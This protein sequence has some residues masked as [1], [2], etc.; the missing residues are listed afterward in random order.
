MKDY[1]KIYKPPTNF[2][3]LLICLQQIP[4]KGTW[5][6]QDY[7][8]L[9]ERPLTGNGLH[10]RREL[11]YILGKIAYYFVRPELPPLDYYELE[12]LNPLV[13]LFVEPQPDVTRG[14]VVPALK[15]DHFI[16][17]LAAEFILRNL[18][19]G[20]PLAIGHI[21]IT[22][23]L[24]QLLVHSDRWKHPKITEILGNDPIQVLSNFRI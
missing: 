4:I 22:P 24:K 8:H 2:K 17:Y 14:C 9:I 10:T 12:N 3:E 23:Y 20:R 15:D 19:D 21:F 16:P 13:S 5:N 1:E 6:A 18:Q 11:L 7:Y